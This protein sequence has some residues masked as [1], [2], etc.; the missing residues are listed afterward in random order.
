[1]RR[2]HLGIVA[3]LACGGCHSWQTVEPFPAPA[4]CLCGPVRALLAN[5]DTVR[6]DSP[7]A[8]GGALY[9]T[10]ALGDTGVGVRR[11]YGPEQ[12][13]RVD[14]RRVSA[15]R[16]VA[17]TGATLVGIAIVGNVMMGEFMKGVL[18]QPRR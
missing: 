17:L 4:R 9:R 10:E 3:A 15:T 12:V 16:T 8:A 13:I 1:M 2:L 18:S 11:V 7:L 6:L 14:R 5:G